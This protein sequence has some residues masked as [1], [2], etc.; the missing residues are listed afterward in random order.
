[1]LGSGSVL[2]TRGSGGQGSVLFHKPLTFREFFIHPMFKHPTLLDKATG[3]PLLESLGKVWFSSQTRRNFESIDF[4]PPGGPDRLSPD[5]FNSWRGWGVESVEG[6]KHQIYLDHIRENVCSGNDE[7]Y[8][9][10]IAWMAHLIQ[11]PWKKE[12]CALILRSIGEGT[13]KGIFFDTIRVLCGEHGIRIGSAE[14]L[15]DQYNSQLYG[16]VFI[17]ADEATWGGNKKEAAKLRGLVTESPLDYQ[18]KFVPKWQAR[19]FS[20]VGIASNEEWVIPA[21]GSARRWQVFDVDPKRMQ[22]RVYF[23]RVLKSMRGGGYENLFFF[24]ESVDLDDYPDPCVSISTSALVDQKLESLDSVNSWIL[25]FLMNGH[26]SMNSSWPSGPISKRALYDCY[27]G[28]ASIQGIKRRSIEVKVG[29][30]LK[31]VF[32]SLLHLTRVNADEDRPYAWEFPPLDIARK[33]FANNVIRGEV[34]WLETETEK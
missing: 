11:R 14:G 2:D 9:W 19:S 34:E 6:D 1:M 32:G 8:R 23:G 29:R 10:V 18:E 16:K 31:S 28:H 13:G 26:F 33:C 17:F 5:T 3:E 7:W 20:R 27:V 21:A 30:R 25:D 22:D 24:L 4:L 12:T 15:T